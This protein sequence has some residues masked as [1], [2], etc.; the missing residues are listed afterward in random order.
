M[1]LALRFDPVLAASPNALSP[2]APPPLDECEIARHILKRSARRR[3][4]DDI[5]RGDP[6]LRDELVRETKQLLAAA[7]YD[8]LG[9]RDWL[10]A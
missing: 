10:L 5:L 6:H 3:D 1:S 4:V 8:V 9:Y 7:R 2:A